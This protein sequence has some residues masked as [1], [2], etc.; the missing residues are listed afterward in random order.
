M[1]DDCAAYETPAIR[2]RL[3]AH[4]RFH[5]HLTPT[6]SSW[7]DLV[8]RWFAELTDRQ[9]RRGAHESVQALEKDIRDWIATRNTD[10][11][12]CIWTRPPM[13]SSNGSPDVRTDLL[14][15]DTGPRSRSG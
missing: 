11:E 6:G 12:P 4:A 9:V 10:P 8:E 7:L 15:Q 1:L 5:L 14:A 13:R 2:T 3:V